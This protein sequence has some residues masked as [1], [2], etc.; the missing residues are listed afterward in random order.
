MSEYWATIVKSRYD[1]GAI[2]ATKVQSYV[3]KLI[4][5]AECNAILGVV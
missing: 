3:P 4:T 5:Q 1:A 2:D